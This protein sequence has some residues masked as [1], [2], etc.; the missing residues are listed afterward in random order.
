MMAFIQKIWRMPVLN[1]LCGIMKSLP[2][3]SLEESGWALGQ[4]SI[5]LYINSVTIVLSHR[6]KWEVT[7]YFPVGDKLGMECLCNWYLHCALDGGGPGSMVT[8]LCS[9]ICCQHQIWGLAK[10]K[11]LLGPLREFPCCYRKT[12]CMTNKTKKYYTGAPPRE[13]RSGMDWHVHHHM[14]TVQPWSAL[15]ENSQCC[16]QG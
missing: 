7:E 1:S 5:F 2:T 8:T 14:V 16:N 13:E 12:G 15:W 6:V 11:N 9:L 4:V 3:I 10:L